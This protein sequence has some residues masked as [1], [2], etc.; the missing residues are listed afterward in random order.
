MNFELELELERVYIYV[1]ARRWHNFEHNRRPEHKGIIEHN[2][3]KNM[4]IL[5]TKILLL[6][7]HKSCFHIVL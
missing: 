7:Y 6:S 5:F 2:R 3:K 1:L 4:S